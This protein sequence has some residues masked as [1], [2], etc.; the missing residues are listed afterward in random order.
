MKNKIKIASLVGLLSVLPAKENAT[1]QDAK[2]V[3][4]LRS[5]HQVK[6]LPNGY[7]TSN[8]IEM[9]IRELAGIYNGGITVYKEEDENTITHISSGI[10]SQAEDPKS[11]EKVLKNADINKDRI[12]TRKE[13][14]NLQEKVYEKYAKNIK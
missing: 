3:L 10:Y 6:N 11:Y 1:I 7:K 13:A 8:S 14:R 12:I 9:T 4:N 5:L 2:E